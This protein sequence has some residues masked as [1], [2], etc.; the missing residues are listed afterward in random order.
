MK[1]PAK[2]QWKCPRCGGLSAYSPPSKTCSRCGYVVRSSVERLRVGPAPKR[3]KLASLKREGG[4]ISAVARRL[5]V[6]DEGD[7]E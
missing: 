6:D 4:R 7:R 5:A 2:M 3:G 1:R